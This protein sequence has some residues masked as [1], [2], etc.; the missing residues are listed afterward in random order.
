[1]ELSKFSSELSLDTESSF[2]PTDEAVGIF[3]FQYP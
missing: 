1:M 2:E 3:L